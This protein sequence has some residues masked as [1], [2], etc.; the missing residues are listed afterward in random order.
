MSVSRKFSEGEDKTWK[1]I[2]NI[3]QYIT[4][5]FQFILLAVAH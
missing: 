3:F 1:H 2:I 5:H 4:I